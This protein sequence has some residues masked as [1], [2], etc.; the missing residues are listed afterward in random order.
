MS[1]LEIVIHSTKRPIAKSQKVL[2]D[3][4]A[5]ATIPSVFTEGC[6]GTIRGANMT[7]TFDQPE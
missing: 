2:Y 5:E 6:P 3:K 4:V 7:L 1:K